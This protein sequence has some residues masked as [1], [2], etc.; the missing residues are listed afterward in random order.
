M[1]SLPAA[2]SGAFIIL[3]DA[4]ALNIILFYGLENLLFHD[5]GYGS[6]WRAGA[7]GVLF[8]AL[9][10]AVGR[11]EFWGAR[12]RPRQT[13]IQLFCVAL[14]VFAVHRI[15]QI[16]PDE[17]G[18]TEFSWIRVELIK[19]PLWLQMHLRRAP[20]FAALFLAAVAGFVFASLRRPRNR[21]LPVAAG[22]AALFVVF[23]VVYFFWDIAGPKVGYMIFFAGP[24]ALFLA[25]F[26]LRSYR[27]AFRLTP[28]AFH[29]L[30]VFLFYVGDLPWRAGFAD[31]K[32][33]DRLPGVT[34]VFSP[35][36][37]GRKGMSFTRN[38][39]VTPDEI[40]LAY[41]PMGVTQF[42]AIDR[43]SNRLREARV[44]GLIRDLRLAADGK[45][46]WAINWQDRALQVLDGRTL[47]VRC[48][49]PLAP[50]DLYLP[51]NMAVDDGKIYI[52]NVTYPIVAEFEADIGADRCRL[53]P[54]RQ[55]NLYKS[56]YTRFTDGAYGLYLDRARRKL[57]ATTA[58]LEAQYLTGLL[59]IDLDSF[60]VAREVRMP[61]GV[62]IEPVEGTP[63]IL[64]PSYYYDTIF[65]IS[66]AEMRVVRAIK[67]VGNI[68]ALK[69]DKGRGLIYAASKTS[70]ELLVF[71]YATGKILT[72]VLVGAR[73]GAM[74]YERESDSLWVASRLG[75]VKIDLRTFLA[76][77]TPPQ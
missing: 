67:A 44:P 16:L 57:Y 26:S 47:A 36:A 42:A 17:V 35:P 45:N 5:V 8:V 15:A 54:R 14:F 29:M 56:G 64:F 11:I 12:Q 30:L 72:R 43:S 75:I 51:W 24:P 13:V 66:L 7:L 2:A 46:L 4:A 38:L 52:S 69:Y 49:V 18:E 70:G 77:L 71:D 48:A 73:P 21:V 65:E 3:I 32:D 23:R 53:T 40:Y 25:L 41:G 50:L 22:A 37:P 58:M 19:T 63:N 33:L 62:T 74:A 28:L 27:M 34:R 76:K 68:M 61:G 39:M 10:A 31:A 9:F 55:L 60:T 6:L 1:I 20:V 59:E